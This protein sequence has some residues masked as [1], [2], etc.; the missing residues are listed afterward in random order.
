ML[1]PLL[2]AVLAAAALPTVLSAQNLSGDQIL[3]RAGS[4]EGLHSFSA[5]VQFDVR[6]HK[7]IGVKTSAQG[8]VYFKAPAQAALS[9]TKMPSILGRFFKSTY[10]IDLAPQVWPAKYTVQSVS[11]AQRGGA[12]V[13]VLDAMPKSDPSVDHVVFEVAKTGFTPLSATWAYKDGSSVA[14]HMTVS[15]SSGYALPQTESVAVSMPQYSLDATVN[16]GSY[17][18]N[19]SIPSSVFSQ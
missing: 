10:A 18:L 16:Y 5:P 8:V 1:K 2:Y 11:E 17:A 13:Y 3:A 6:M 12:D 19:D 15:S 7:P 9:I 14:L 4:S